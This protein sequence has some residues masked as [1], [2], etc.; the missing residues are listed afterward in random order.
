[1][2]KKQNKAKAKKQAERD[3]NTERMERHLLKTRFPLECESI[4][5]EALTLEEQDVVN[6]CIN[7][8]HLD[9]DEFTLL[10]ATL[11]KYRPAIE[12]YQ[13]T[14]T[15]DAFEK[16]QKTITTEEEWLNLLDNTDNTLKV[17][18]PLKGKWYEME[19][20]ILPLDDSR[21]VQTLQTH[22]DLFKDYSP[23]EIQLYSKA[24]QGQT[25]TPEEAAIVS[26]M[27]KDLESRAS[28]DRIKYINDF[29]TS[30]LRLPNSTQDTRK[31]KLFWEKFP[32]L[33]KSAIMIK[34]EDYL[35]LTE[36]SNEKLFP[37]SQ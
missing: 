28:E 36:Y 30:Q 19:F 29:L 26:K 23:S 1:M 9:D 25:I 8:E 37:D 2:S 5:L 17:N 24:Q 31:R 32:F 4:P 18:V 14:E 27:N 35:G 20:E 13:P 6:K 22:V 11:A 34:V 16:T 12:K 15:I 33:V 3:G 10:K 21:I 7:H